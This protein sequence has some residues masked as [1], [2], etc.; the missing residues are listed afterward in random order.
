MRQLD[1]FTRSLAQER[2]KA[3]GTLVVWLAILAPV[4]VVTVAFMASYLDGNRLYRSNVN[5]W[6]EYSGHILIG[7]TLFVFPIYASLQSALVH[8]IEH[9]SQTWKTLFSLP[10]PKWSVYSAKLAL[11][12][13][14][15][16]LSHVLVLGLAEGGGWLLGMLKPHYGFQSSSLHRVLA[17]GCFA[18]LLSG[19]GMAAIQFFLGI[20]FGSFILPAGVGLMLTMLGAISRSLSVSRVSPY[21]WPVLVFNSS[22]QI[23]DWQFTY[24]WIGLLTFFLASI[25]GFLIIYRRDVA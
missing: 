17:E 24:V 18:S 19:L 9:Q 16:V 20:R 5:P 11:F 7:W 25:G 10:M 4:F 23:Q 1:Y 21:L 12:T 14:L 13:G 8:A 6:L 15:L 2:L 3:K 22:I